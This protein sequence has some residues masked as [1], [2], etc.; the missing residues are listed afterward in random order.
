MWAVDEKQDT[1]L[2]LPYT[3]KSTSCTWLTQQAWSTQTNLERSG[4]GHAS[5]YSES[6]H[7]SVA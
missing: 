6:H 2:L 5:S 4:A 3:G 1:S 7:Y